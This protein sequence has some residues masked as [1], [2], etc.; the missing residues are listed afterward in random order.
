M[1]SDAGIGMTLTAAAVVALGLL[2]LA[3]RRPWVALLRCGT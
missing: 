1:M 3:G 2:A